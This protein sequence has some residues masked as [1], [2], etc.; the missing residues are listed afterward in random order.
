M[1]LSDKD[2]NAAKTMNTHLHILEAYSSLYKIA[3]SQKLQTALKNLL[4]LFTERFLNQDYN[5]ELF[6]D[7]NW[8]L[9]SNQ[10]SFGHD[11]ETLWLVI[12]AAK[13][14]D[15]QTLIKKTEHIALP[16]ADR[17]LEL[18]YIKHGGVLNEVN[19]ETNHIDSD[20][21]WWPQAEAMVGLLYAYSISRNSHYKSAILDIWMFT[22]KYIIDSVNGEWH[23]RIDSDFTP[24]TS[25]NKLGMWKCPY[26]NTRAC[27]QLLK[28]QLL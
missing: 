3:P 9:T 26:H 19:R 8:N 4:G 11:I 1:R 18:G 17:F 25:E 21:H 2:Q 28:N 13:T 5:F 24:Y 15:D 12:E 23:F 10:I 7:K 16:I 14:I 27:I 22:K 20:R 6:F